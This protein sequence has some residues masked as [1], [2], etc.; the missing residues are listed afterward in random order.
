[1]GGAGIMGKRK[2]SYQEVADF[3]KKTGSLFYF[4]REDSNIFVPKASGFG[5]TLN[6]AN[7]ISWLFIV[8][9]V[10]LLIYGSRF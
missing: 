7:P 5:R 2:W 10:A 1:M 6:F 9:V 8:A 4:N 3:R